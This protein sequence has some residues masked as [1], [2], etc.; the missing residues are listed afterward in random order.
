[1]PAVPPEATE[2]TS[3]IGDILASTD[4]IAFVLFDRASIAA[5]ATVSGRGEFPALFFWD[6]RC[7]CWIRIRF[8]TSTSEYP[9][10]LMAAGIENLVAGFASH[11]RKKRAA[12]LA[13]SSTLYSFLFEDVLK[14]LFPI[15]GKWIPQIM[16]PGEREPIVRK[17]Q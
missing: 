8:M 3:G 1:M 10:A 6:S 13:R 16:C 17:P 4:P 2:E 12:F 7:T 11:A 15:E 14:C 9:L 5:A